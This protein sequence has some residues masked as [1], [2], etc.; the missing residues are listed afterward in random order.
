MAATGTVRLD[1]KKLAV[2]GTSWMK[3][4]GSNQLGQDTV[5]WD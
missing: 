5:G 2:S 1:G 3:E 4:Y